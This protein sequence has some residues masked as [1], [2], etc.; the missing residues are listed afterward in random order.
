M[1]IGKS[2]TIIEQDQFC[3]PEAQ[4][5]KIRD[6][7]DW[8][9]PS[10]IDWPKLHQAIRTANQTNQVVL[11]EGLFVLDDKL[12]L[13]QYDL[14]IEMEITRDTFFE[15]RKKETRW[16]HEPEWYINYVWQCYQKRILIPK[17]AI[18]LSGEEIKSL[19]QNAERVIK[20]LID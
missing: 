6:R 7:Y 16:G 13:N 3:T 17:N 10:S 8:E 4:L 2:A 14:V 19:H 9:Q 15:R 11:I 20:L 5:P 12:Y 1:S 18:R